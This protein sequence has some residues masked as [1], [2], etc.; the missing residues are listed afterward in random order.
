MCKLMF[1]V[2]LFKARSFWKEY[3]KVLWMKNC[4]LQETDSESRKLMCYRVS[5]QNLHAAI[6]MHLDILL[7]LKYSA[8]IN[9]YLCLRNLSQNS[10]KELTL[11]NKLCHAL[12]CHIIITSS[13]KDLVLLKVNL[14]GNKQKISSNVS[15]WKSLHQK[16]LFFPELKF[17]ATH[18]Q[19][20]RH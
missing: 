20:V 11:L 7:Q 14:M 10:W 1:C 12:P 9:P 6:L 5:I 2:L 8:G 13:G 17:S 16:R 19:N 15:K 18:I 3:H 4:P